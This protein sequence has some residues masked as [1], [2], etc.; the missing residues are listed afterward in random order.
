MTD[1][2]VYDPRDPVPDL[3]G[4]GRISIATEQ[5]P[6][7]RR[8]DIL[9]YQSAPLTER[10]EVTGNPSV[11]LAAC[12]TAPDTDFFA[13]LIDVS[14]EGHAREVSMGL[15]R[16]RY[17][18]GVDRPSLVPAGSRV[19]Y[20]IRMSATSNAFLP[21]HRIRL[22]ITS[23]CF[24]SYDRNHNTGADQYADP[25]LV[26]ATQTVLHGGDQGTRLVL[27]CIPNDPGTR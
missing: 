26:P 12:S 9:V 4:P 16:T 6:L 24:P 27:P 15:V 17:R 19:A 25:E 3:Y 1:T 2:Y 21:G 18:N 23:S 22:D 20:R 7:A 5:A 14:P 13:R 10:I 8:Q 11:E